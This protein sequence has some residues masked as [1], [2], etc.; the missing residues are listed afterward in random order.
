MRKLNAYIRID[1]NLISIINGQQMLIK[2]VI[3]INIFEILFY[4]PKSKDHNNLQLLQQ[5][6]LK[7]FIISIKSLKSCV[8]FILQ[9][10][11]E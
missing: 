3:N 7:A 9:H 8:E 11:I 6:L 1:S 5:E 4:D 10:V 2:T